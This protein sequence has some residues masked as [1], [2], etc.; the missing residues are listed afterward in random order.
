MVRL[1]LRSFVFFLFLN[2]AEAKQTEMQL[3][4]NTETGSAKLGAASHD[5]G[6]RLAAAVNDCRGCERAFQW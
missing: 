4:W 2:C 1:M 5:E 3:L 6:A